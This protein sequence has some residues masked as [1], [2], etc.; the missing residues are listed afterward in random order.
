MIVIKIYDF[1]Y[2][3]IKT[4]TNQKETTE[5]INRMILLFVCI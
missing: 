3:F 2:L 5:K 4:N 1:K